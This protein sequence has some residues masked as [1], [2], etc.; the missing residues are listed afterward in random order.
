M[1][2]RRVNPEEARARL[3]LLREGVGKKVRALEA[4]LAKKKAPLE[5]ALQEYRGALEHLRRL[6]GEGRYPE[7][8]LRPALAREELR[9]R[10]VEGEIARLEEAH[11]QAVAQLVSQVRLKAARLAALAQMEE[12]LDR[13][14]PLPEIKEE[15]HA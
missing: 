14:F 15:A 2:W 13:F 9:I 5:K 4:Q 6:E 1:L 11:R 7:A 3:A 8:V 12:A 10:Y